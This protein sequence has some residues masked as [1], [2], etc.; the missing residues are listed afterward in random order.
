ML[1]AAFVAA[2]GF[3]PLYSTSS[4]A[5]VIGGFEQVRVVAPSDRV[6]RALQ[7]N[8]E[9]LLGAG[10]QAAKY[11]LELYPRLEE[12]GLAVQADADITRKNLSLVTRFVLTDIASGEKVY[13]STSFSIASYNR[14]DSEYANIIARRDAEERS[15]RNVAQDIRLQLGIYFDRQAAL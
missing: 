3:R 8:V 9:D 13:E 1:M 2:C 4:N 11:K 6:G 15:A 7:F 5:N 14:V 10:K 12:S